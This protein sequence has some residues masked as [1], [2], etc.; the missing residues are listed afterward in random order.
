MTYIIVSDII[1]S[2]IYI[3]NYILLIKFTNKVNDDPFESNL[4]IH[5]QMER[6]LKM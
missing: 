3:L 6:K 4:D 2:Y 1:I 5:S